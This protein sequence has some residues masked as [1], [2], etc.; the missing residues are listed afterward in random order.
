[1]S[2]VKTLFTILYDIRLSLIDFWVVANNRNS[3]STVYYCC[4]YFSWFAF[5]LRLYP[6]THNHCRWLQ[7]EHV[8]T[9]LL[10]SR[11]V[12][13]ACLP[14]TPI[15]TLLSWL[16]HLVHS[17]LLRPSLGL[18]RP[19]LQR[20]ESFL[21]NHLPMYLDDKGSKYTDVGHDS[22]TC[23]RIAP[24]SICFYFYVLTLF[25]CP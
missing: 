12:W 17:N 19:L 24:I 5:K 9:H 6:L 10:R 4:W 25:P 14:H 23:R 13:L 2:D 18:L 15:E 16:P 7:V 1:M 21:Y 3:C 11:D 8:P 22:I 20:L